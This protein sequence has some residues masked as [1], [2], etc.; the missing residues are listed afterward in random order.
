MNIIEYTRNLEKE[1]ENIEQLEHSS[2]IENISVAIKRDIA[3]SKV[4]TGIDVSNATVENLQ[5]NTAG[6]YYLGQNRIKIDKEILD[7]GDEKARLQ[8]LVHESMHQVN[9]SRSNGVR[10]IDTD[11]LE[12]M[13]ELA[14][15]RRTGEFLAENAKKSDAEKIASKVGKS[16]QAI[17]DMYEEGR[18]TELNEYYSRAA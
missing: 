16:V 13:N 4:L 11:F 9:D 2:D 18:N 1:E 17:V 14:T 8:V 12:S 10:I 3:K 7:S 5:G 15:E 6:L